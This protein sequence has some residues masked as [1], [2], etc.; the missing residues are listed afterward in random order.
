MDDRFTTEQVDPAQA[1]NA[2]K[3]YI[4]LSMIS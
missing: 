1:L 3:M 4:Q 2:A